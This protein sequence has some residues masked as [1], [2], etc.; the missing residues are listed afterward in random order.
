LKKGSLAEIWDIV[1]YHGTG[2]HGKCTEPSN[3]GK[4]NPGILSIPLGFAGAMAR[5]V[6][7][8]AEHK[9]TELE[10]RENTGLAPRRLRRTKQPGRTLLAKPAMKVIQVRRELDKLFV[11][12]GALIGK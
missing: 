12:P 3:A 8:G 2:Y 1:C 10:V 9:F 6:D 4:E 5:R 7:T 11:T